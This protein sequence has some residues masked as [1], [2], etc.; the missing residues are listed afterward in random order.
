MPPKT[1]ITQT[2]KVKYC[3][4]LIPYSLTY[5]FARFQKYSS[6]WQPSSSP[7]HAVVYSSW[8]RLHWVSETLCHNK[9]PSHRYVTAHYMAKSIWTL[10]PH[11]HMWVR[12]TRW[13]RMSCILQYYNFAST[14]LVAIT[15][16]KHL[17]HQASK[18]RCMDQAEV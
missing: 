6:T 9:G 3:H 11:T 4:V 7:S 2:L 1:T 13:S 10:D 17:I 14:K 18:R 12:G 16:K 15:N 5:S 8:Q